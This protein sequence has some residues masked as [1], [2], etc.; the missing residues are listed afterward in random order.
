MPRMEAM[1]RRWPVRIAGTL[2]AGAL[3]VTACGGGS[4]ATAPPS[5]YLGTV[6]DKPVPHSVAD[7][8]LTTDAGRMTSLAAL[9]GQ[10]VVLAD[11]L[12][13]CQETCPLTT[14]N[15]LMMDR[16]V[17]AAGLGRRVRFVELTV[18]P[19]RDT[20]SRL[21]A[22]RALVG[23]RANWSLLTG[24]PAVIERIWRF[25]GVWYQR[26]A[27][28]RPPGTDW[29]TGKPLTYDIAHQDAVIY[30]DAGGRERFL[31]VGSPNATRAPVAP[32]LRRF[33]SAQGRSRLNHPDASTWTAAE[34]LS[35]IAWLTGRPIRSPGS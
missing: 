27:E 9:H 12:T 15:L 29:L 21:R 17:A 35:P 25:F 24:S 33:L 5:A 13:L 8:P 14:G 4:A 20:P 32:A 19:N 31:V 34:A 26:V 10:V 16:A 23:A 6:L 11:F 30:L 22:Y 7:L 18:D 28:D 2:A 3:V 1:V